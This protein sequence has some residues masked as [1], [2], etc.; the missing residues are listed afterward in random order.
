MGITTSDLSG[1][2]N[3]QI[4]GS[5]NFLGNEAS[6]VVTVTAQLT[7]SQGATFSLPVD[8]TD[9]TDATDVS[10]DT[11]ALRVEG[12][13]SIAKK[14]YV[15]TDALV[16]G[17]LTVGDAGAEDQKIVLD[18]NAA[19]YY[20]G[21]DD[22][23]DTF[24][25]GLGSTVG[26]NAAFTINTNGYIQL[27]LA[28]GIAI[29]GS[30]I[31]GDA[32]SDVITAKAQLTASQGITITGT[33]PRL[34][35]G[36]GE[37]EDT[38]IVLDGNAEDYY[39]A[40]DDTDDKLHFGKGQTAGTN[41]AFTVD[42]NA[43][44]SFK[45]TT[46]TTSTTTG[47]AIF[48]GGVG[49]ADDLV[50]GDNLSLL[51]D[52]AVLNMGAGNDFTITHDGTTGATLAG[53]PITIN[54]T[55]NLTLDSTTDIV[56]SGSS[57][58]RVENDVRLDSDS[59]VL[60]MGAND[61][62]TLTHDGT[63]G[64]TVAANPITLDSGG[65]IVLD[66]DGAN[67][68]LKD[69]GTAYLDFI[70]SSGNCILSSS[71]DTKDI[72][73]HGD[74]AAEV[75]RVD[76]DA[77]SLLMASGKELQFA[78]AGEH[79]S[80]DGSTL[81][82]VSEAGSIAIGAALAD[83]Q[84]LKLGK[85]G[86]V[87]TI[88]AP[89]GTAGSEKY[90]VTNTAGTAV[91]TDG[92]SDSAVQLSSLAGGV[93]IRTT[94]NLAGAIQIEAD[95]GA[96]ETII[97]K[98]DQGTGADSIQV[99]SD[100]GGIDV[101]SAKEI[102]LT[103]NA[104]A[105]HIALV[106]AHTAGVA[107]H[108]DANA[109]AGSIV[110]ID[111]GI[112]DIDVTAGTTIDTTGVTI[113]DSTT[114]SGTEGGS[115]RLVSNDGATMAEEHRLGVLEFAGAEDGSSTITVGARIEAICDV[116]WS[117]IDNGTSLSFY[118][119]SGNATQAEKM[120]LTASGSLGIGTGDPSVGTNNNVGVN[121][122]NT[123]ASH[124]RAGGALR[125]S[126]NDGAAMASGHRLGVLEFAGAEDANGED[127][128]IT[129]GARIEALC[130]SSWSSTE[131]GTDLLFYTTNGNASQ[132]ERMRITADGEVVLPTTTKLSFHD[133]TGGENIVA[134]ANGHLEINSGTT[135]DMTA[136]TVDV[137][138]STA[139]TIDTPGVTITD[140][141]TSA[142]TE[143]GFLRLASNDGAAM[144]E[145]H[146]LGVLEFAGAE[147]GSGTITVGAR[148]EAICD[149][150]W[151]AIDNGTSLSFYTT[152]GNATQ[153][154]KMILTA[155]G[156]LGIG[157]G[158]PSVGTTNTLGLEVQNSAAS[159]AGAGGAI[160]ISCNDGAAMASG[161]RL[162]VLEFAGA[163]DANGEDA[164]ITVGA[165]I[166]ALC[167]ASWSASENGTSMLFYTTDGNASQSQVLKLTSDKQA[168]FSGRVVESLS[169]TENDAQNNTLSA[170]EIKGG[171]VVHTSVTGGGT[172]T[173]D[174]ASNIISG[175]PLSADGDCVKVYYIN[176][177]NQDLTFANGSGV[178]VQDTGAMLASDEGLMLIFRRTSASAVT[179]YTIGGGASD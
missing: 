80:G 94:S 51:S 144:A 178:T 126:C 148:I 81:S 55:G 135:L 100:A 174:T 115:I 127:A 156:S 116:N 12:G 18:G 159:A 4:S 114:S 124:A 111:A 9:T 49:I 22:T 31:L 71:A 125:I 68:T 30:T 92:N 89:H 50:V 138:A 102:V 149:A 147:D 41:S 10:G 79:I 90:S 157:T 141:T 15:G 45:A 167:D 146:R 177:G 8:I 17:N 28:A 118:T 86:A 132:T 166:E 73:F 70:Q 168:A 133:E 145:E 67:I 21:L 46:A 62:I 130:D 131:N 151:S 54:S 64:L 32:G 52:S 47:G 48:A 158:G 33:N 136:P 179:M 23:D 173:T 140:A 150:A 160:R 60:S 142:E 123:G 37:A 35:V 101:D 63:T 56:L 40:I 170:A 165:R 82:I 96:S 98:A 117:A 120:I 91:M 88:I 153:A 99:V 108:I 76:G 59:S 39:L 109:N 161:H 1:S 97:I 87:E 107:V 122:E 83:G 119:T 27:P 16:A 93:G 19:D 105:G 6:D 66:A 77:K 155:S 2:G 103:T 152:S 58:V 128:V 112:L 34:T 44:V 75:V 163:E 121:I 85:N 14:L 53:T 113:T 176:D 5:T 169:V 61:D 104:A 74:D 13:A 95:G 29:S 154:E 110:D 57:E 175:V 162:G 26:T 78:D 84:T 171:I 3:L 69:A 129:V 42:T 134:S 172:V 7:A 137:N 25:L 43:Q 106:S 36:D 65:D 24:K 143:G 38:M 139:V 164:V 11:G 20:L 72:I